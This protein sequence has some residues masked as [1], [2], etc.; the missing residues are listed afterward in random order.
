L[1]EGF[2]IWVAAAAV[3]YLLG[4]L[5]TAYLLV[6]FF[7]RKNVMDLGTGNVGTLNVHRATSSKMLTLLTL[8]G[9]LTK[10]YVAIVIGWLLARQAGLDFG[11][12]P[13][14]WA[15][16]GDHIGATIAGI[17]AILGHNYSIF[18]RFKGGK[19]IT[20]SASMGFYF[21]PFIVG[22]WVLSFFLTVAASRWLVLGQMVAT[23]AMPVFCYFLYPEAAIASYFVA[24]LVLLRH[25]PRIKS[26]LDGTEP[27]LYY[28]A[29]QPS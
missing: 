13:W 9:D 19:G 23:A 12:A 17:A 22:F 10:A 16:G 1:V 24:A 2:W 28:K 4:S 14:P 11:S 3:G 6:R 29:Q 15:M 21:H 25:A 18:L 5:P 7:T 8:L 20:C 27:K 26:L